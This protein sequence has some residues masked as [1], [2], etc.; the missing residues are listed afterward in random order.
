[1]ADGETDPDRLAE[2]GDDRLGC[3][4]RE[5]RAALTG[6]LEPIHRR[7][8]RLY[9]DRLHLQDQQIG[10]L[11]Q[12]MATALQPQ[13]DAVIRLA[14]VPGFGADSAQQLIAE[15]G[16]DAEAFPSAGQFTSRAG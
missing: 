12:M 8:L 6:S 3:S 1:M 4:D 14:E 11:D 10:I 9:M 5:L 16:A 2:L 13:Q 7:L 15:I